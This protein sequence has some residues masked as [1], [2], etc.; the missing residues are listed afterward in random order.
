MDTVLENWQVQVRKGLL[1]L[2]VLNS[3]RA[4]KQYGYDIVKQLRALDGLVIGEG[5]IYPIL[6]RFRTQGLVEATIEESPDGPPRKYYRLT[7]EGRRTVGQM[8]EAWDKIHSGVL[9][10][11][12]G[13]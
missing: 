5:T 2:C 12:G 10:L 9:S 1:E 4:G 11:R 7:T 8:N 6:S 13:D 3:L